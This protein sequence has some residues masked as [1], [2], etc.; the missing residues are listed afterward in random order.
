MRVFADWTDP[1]AVKFKGVDYGPRPK[2]VQTETR[3]HVV[4]KIPG[5]KYFGGIGIQ[6]NA[7]LRYVVFEKEDVPDSRDKGPTKGWLN[8]IVAVAPRQPERRDT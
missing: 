7:P 6:L 3:R 8:E 2:P 5:H 4:V 1:E